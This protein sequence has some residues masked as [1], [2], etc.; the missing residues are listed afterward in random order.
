MIISED[1]TA[2]L[3]RRQLIRTECFLIL[4][5]LLGSNTLFGDAFKKI[6]EDNKYNELVESANQKQ[7][8]INQQLDIEQQ[9]IDQ[10]ERR[11]EIV[12]VV[13]EI[14]GRDHVA[15]EEEIIRRVERFAER[16]LF[17]LL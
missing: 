11:Q 9:Q 14:L 10:I 17:F 12:R 7:L 13:D 15:F 3:R 4:A 5:N 6:E 16:I 8:Q 2:D 1:N